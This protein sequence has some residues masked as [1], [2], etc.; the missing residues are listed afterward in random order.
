[1]AF[2]I[3]IAFIPLGVIIAKF[4]GQYVVSQVESAFIKRLLSKRRFRVGQSIGHKDWNY[5]FF[6]TL[7][8]VTDL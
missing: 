5:L 4:D 6:L 2:D 8:D 3:F 1:V 7:D